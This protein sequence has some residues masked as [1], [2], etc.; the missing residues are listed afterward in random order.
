V[1]EHIAELARALKGRARTRHG[2]TSG[3]GI[4]R[5]LPGERPAATTE[6]MNSLSSFQSSMPHGNGQF[7]EQS[8]HYPSKGWLP[9]PAREMDQLHAIR[10]SK[11][12]RLA[13]ASG[14]RRGDVMRVQALL[15]RTSTA[16]RRAPEENNRLV[17]SCGASTRVIR[18]TP[19]DRSRL[20]FARPWRSF[21]RP[22]SPEGS[23]FEAGRAGGDQHAQSCLQR[24]TPLFVPYTTSGF[25]SPSRLRRPRRTVQH[26]SR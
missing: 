5:P 7:P 23:S 15:A 8:G 21:S 24:T 14:A 19:V 6:S 1:L 17:L 26:V 2:S 22:A 25:R 4:H 13:E 11:P 3:C 9:G 10:L 20:R 12:I 16:G 18:H